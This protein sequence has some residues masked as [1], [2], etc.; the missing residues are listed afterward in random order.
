[1]LRN[2]IDRLQQQLQQQQSV[3]VN[4]TWLAQEN[5]QLHMQVAQLT[6]EVQLSI[7]QTI[8]RI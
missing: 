3:S 7:S 5:Q 2:E 4:D 6:Q 8:V 1:M